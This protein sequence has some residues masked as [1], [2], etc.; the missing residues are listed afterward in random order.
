[1]RVACLGGGP[2]GLSFA[3]LA[4]R[5][6]PDWS[7]E[8]WDRNPPGATYGFGVVFSDEAM[9]AIRR[10]DDEIHAQIKSNCASWGEIDV[11]FRDRMQTSGG[12]GFSA[13]SRSALVGLMQGRAS[14]LGVV[15]HHETEAPSPDDLGGYDLIVG[16]DGVTSVVRARYEATFQPTIEHGRC[17]FI[18]LAVDEAY[19][20]FKFFIVDTPHG[21]VQIHAYPYDENESTFIV[22]M[23]DDVW[24]RAGFGQFE[25]AAQKPGESDWGSIGLVGELLADLL[26]G[27]KLLANNSKWLRFP[28]VRIER[29]YHDN[30]ALIGDAAH[31]AHFSIGSA[32][33][34]AVEDAITL[35]QSLVEEGDVPTALAAYDAAR[36]PL[37]ASTQRA[38]AASRQW[39]EDLPQYLH[40]DDRQFVFNLLTRSRRITY[41]NLRLRDEEFV[42]EV[43]EWFAE[44]VVDQVA[45]AQPLAVRPPMFMPFKL[46]GLE[47]VNRVV[48]SPMDMYSAV[49]GYVSDFHF[50]HLGARALGGAG[51]VMSEML[52]VSPEGRITPGCAGL[53]EEGQVEAWRR[54]VS[55]IHDNSDAKA[56]LQLGHS[57]R[58]GSTKLLWEGVDLPLEDGNWEIIAPSPLPYLEVSQVPREMEQRDFEAV[59]AQYV[60]AAELGLTAGF[61]LLELHMAH[62][63]LLSSFLTPVSNRRTDRYG[64][65]LENRMRFPLEVFDA[66]R[67]TWPDEKPMT[68]RISATDWVPGGFGL[69]DAVVFAGA[70]KEYGCDAIDVSTG[71]TTIDARPAYG[72]SYQTP[73]ADAIRNRVRIPTI[74]VGAISSSDDVNSIVLAGRAD[75]CA[76]ARPHLYDPAWTLHAAADQAYAGDGVRWPVQ[77]RTGSRP[78]Q[79]G[80][81]DMGVE[82]SPFEP[83]A[84][85][86]RRERWRPKVPAAR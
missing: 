10:M 48:V 23:R 20:A 2:G 47:L 50:V 58:K 3:V 9:E 11:H 49:D 86:E 74:A 25:G 77:Y 35:V 34:L 37:V 26:D 53:W 60:R 12:H 24:E 6:S 42:R 17:K 84:P 13:L 80:R 64:G 81:R 66:V 72:R 65:S 39:F 22:E 67:S 46:R 43:D 51:L 38:A 85:E 32:T 16:A 1:M 62:G 31:T 78:P 5:I 36:K 21:V 41:D 76:L 75:L 54:I 73:F 83:P 27:R 18:W 70:L 63:Y 4:K 40:Q 28:T 57:G 56:G 59:L 8:V 29:W 45:S 61:E 79:V 7:V 68:V 55:F 14:D 52:C 71:Q 19:D 33:K 30:V 82:P 69:D 15:L 44:E